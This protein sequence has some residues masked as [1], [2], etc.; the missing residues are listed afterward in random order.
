MYTYGQ[1]VWGSVDINRRV[2]ITASNNTFTF[3]V[4]D[5]SYTI[6]IPD[7]TYTTTRQRHESELVQ[8][9]SKAG[10]AQNIP[11]KFI[12]GGMHYDEKYNVLILEHTDTSNEHVIDQFAGNALDT[13]FG[14]VK[15]NLPPRK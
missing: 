5:S 12:L 7:G 3:N 6:T 1:Q 13:L 11:V 8:A 9:I 4:D 14:Q 10:A 2:T 15:F